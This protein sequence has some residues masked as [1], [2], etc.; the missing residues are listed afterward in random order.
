MIA[1][2]GVGAAFMYKTGGSNG[3]IRILE[4]KL[5]TKRR[6]LFLPYILG[7]LVF[8]NDYA[9]SAIV[10]NASKD[11]TGKNKVSRKKLAYILD[12]ISAPRATICQVSDWFGHKVS[13]I[14]GSF[15]S[16]TMVGVQTDYVFFHS[17]PW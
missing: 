4:S 12:S 11:I 15:A 3:F 10:G 2:L 8:F 16:A 7:I 17:I 9:N 1:L 6:V 14:A 13:I 5:T